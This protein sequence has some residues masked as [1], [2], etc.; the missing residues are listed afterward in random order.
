MGNVAARQRL[1]FKDF[2]YIAK[3]T[4]F[5]SRGVREP[6]IIII[7]C[8]IIINACPKTTEIKHKYIAKNTNFVSREVRR[9]DYQLFVL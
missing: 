9:E 2:A 4:N 6:T 3:N 7:I 1:K 8:L 5:A